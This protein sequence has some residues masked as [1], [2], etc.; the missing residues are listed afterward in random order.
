[1]AAYRFSVAWPR[2]LPDG[3]GAI[4]EAGLDFYDRLLDGLKARGIKAFATLYHWDLPLVLMGRGGWTDRDT[5]RAF[6]DYAKLVTARL[7]DRLDTVVT[8]NEPW[9]SVYMGHLYGRPCAGRAVDGSG[10]GGAS[11]DQSGPWSWGAGNPCGA[12]RAAGWSG[13][14]P[15]ERVGGQRQR[16]GPQGGR[17][18][19]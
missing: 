9:C 6:A 11:R 3:T 8:F 5:A 14:Q 19:Q 17:K 15:D 2:I 12:A 13:A 16:C 4:N 7:G 18:G 1:V 10:D